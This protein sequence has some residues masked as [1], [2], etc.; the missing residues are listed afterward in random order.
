MKKISQ[1]SHLFLTLLLPSFV[2]TSWADVKPGDTIT[3]DNMDQ[4]ETL[5]TPSIGQSH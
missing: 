1:L 2:S 3:K 4:A 5:L